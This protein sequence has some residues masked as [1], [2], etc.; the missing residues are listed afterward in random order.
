MVNLSKTKI[1]I[2][3]AQH[4]CV[5][6]LMLNSAVMEEVESFKYLGFTFLSVGTGSSVA[7]AA[8]AIFAMQQQCALLGIRALLS[9]ATYLPRSC[10]PF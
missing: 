10:H 3:E 5:A 7:A 6:D 4:G 2:F 8:K 1:V 9:S